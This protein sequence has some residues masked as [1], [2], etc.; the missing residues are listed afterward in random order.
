MKRFT[1]SYQLWINLGDGGYTF[2]EFDNLEEA[3]EVEKYT[4]D[5]Y[6]TKRTDYVAREV[7]G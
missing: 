7:E 3:L 6:I 2:T 4:S 1:K 5:W